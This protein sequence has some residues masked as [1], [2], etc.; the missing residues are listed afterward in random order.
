MANG[1]KGGVTGVG[2]AKNSARP[3]VWL[4]LSL[5]RAGFGPFPEAGDSRIVTNPDTP[6]SM[7]A[8][9]KNIQRRGSKPARSSRKGYAID[10]RAEFFALPIVG[11]TAHS[12][13]RPFA[14]SPFAVSPI[15]RHIFLFVDRK[16]D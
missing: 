2:R 8:A 4:A 3:G 12:P 10:R 16:I 7:H 11:H 9:A 1:R 13:C 15:R 14:L 6:I 5:V